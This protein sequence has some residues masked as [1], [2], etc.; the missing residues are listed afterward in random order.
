V[1]VFGA[2]INWWV[3]RRKEQQVGD[4]VPGLA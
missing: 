2:E 1:I 3:A 4:E